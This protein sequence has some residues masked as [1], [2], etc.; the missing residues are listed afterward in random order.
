M[1]VV[2]NNCKRAPPEAAAGLSN[3]SNHGCIHMFIRKNCCSKALEMCF[4]LG[5]TDDHAFLGSEIQ[6]LMVFSTNL[7][8]LERDIYP[9]SNP[10][11]PVWRRPFSPTSR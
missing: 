9:R 6:I 8:Y 11:A 3:S 1:A 4:S 5:Q 10:A 7:W 2:K